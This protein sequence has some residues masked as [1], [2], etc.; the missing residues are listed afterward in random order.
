MAENPTPAVHEGSFVEVMGTRGTS[1]ALCARSAQERKM[2][3]P[4]FV[5]LF[6]IAAFG[7]AM[8]GCGSGASNNSSPTSP[9]STTTTSATSTS[10][11]TT[12]TLT[13]NWS[14][15]LGSP[16]D[17]SPDRLT[18]TATQS[19]TSVTGPVVYTVSGRSPSLRGTM[20]G[21]IS[22]SQVALTFTLP[23]GSWVPVGGPSACSETGTATA[24][25]AATSMSAPM[26]LTFAAACI[27]TV[28]KGSTDTVQLSLA[29]E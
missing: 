25:P 10:P 4:L 28:S 21:A 7:L 12:L 1:G 20:T 17:P 5:R 22:G 13:G 15:S 26:T 16:A 8:S 2:I 18:W 23:A 19:G 9:T 6:C 11:A 14:G 3:R 29:K 24:T 27:G